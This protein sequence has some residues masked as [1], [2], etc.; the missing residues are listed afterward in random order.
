MARRGNG[1]GSITRHRARGNWH[2]RVSLPNGKRRSFYGRTRAEVAAKIA[3]ALG[4]L[5]TG[6]LPATSGGMLRDYLTGWLES[7]VVGH[8]SASTAEHYESMIRLHVVPSIGRLKLSGVTPQVIQRMHTGLRDKGLSAKSVVNVHRMLHKA[9]ATAVLWK[10]IPANPASLAP[11]PRAIR[12][13]ISTLTV[14]Q[15]DHLLRVAEDDRLHALYVLAVSTG[16]RQGELLGLRW[17]DVDF[18]AGNLAVRQQLQRSVNASGRREFVF[19]PP[20]T[21][22]S[23]RVVALPQVALSSLQRHRSQQ[24]EERLRAGSEWTD[25]GLVFPNLIGRPIEKGNLLRRSYWPL[26]ERAGLPHRT[27]HSLRHSHATIL[28]AGGIHPKIVQERLG[29]ANISTTI[30]TYSHVTPSM[31]QAA[32]D[33]LDEV[34]EDAAH[35]R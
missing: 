6:T 9:L 27:F 28:L 29:H 22:A 25:L 32:A 7:S 5:Q 11:P 13:E 18:S 2:G 14:E 1:E 23:V 33:R 10:L 3:D 24:A 20:K 26:L 16:L 12:P 30:D 19:T 31:Q 34:L 21:K 4:K 35:A 8:V 15:I 17:A